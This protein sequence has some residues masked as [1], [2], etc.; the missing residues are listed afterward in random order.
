VIHTDEKMENNMNIS[1]QNVVTKMETDECETKAKISIDDQMDVEDNEAKEENSI[2]KCISSILDVTWDEQCD[3]QN[4]VKETM[5][6]VL[7]G[8]LSQDDFPELISS[9]INEMIRQYL[10]M[11]VTKEVEVSSTSEQVLSSRMRNDDL[12]MDFE[13]TSFA[14]STRQKQTKTCTA[15]E[16]ALYYVQPSLFG[17]SEPGSR[18]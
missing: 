4:I 16:A 18:S 6:A 17:A 5:S 13:E 1:N 12:E 8:S 2:L 7:E 14:D 15:K 9:I 11:S 10:S 3:G